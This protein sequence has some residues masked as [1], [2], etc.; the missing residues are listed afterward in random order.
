MG[1]AVLK[2]RRGLP[3]VAALLALGAA[4]TAARAQPPAPPPVETVEAP[5]EQVVVEPAAGADREPP[6]RPDAAGGADESGEDPVI[7]RIEVRSDAPLD[8]PDELR[9]LIALAPGER[10]TERAVRRTLRNVQ[11]TGEA[12]EV[13]LYTRPAAPLPDVLKRPSSASAGAGG[14]R[15]PSSASAVDVVLVLRAAVQVEELVV[16]GELGRFERNELERE[17][18]VTVRQPLIESR[19][20]RGVFRLQEVYEAWG[21][22]DA[23]V[24]L[25]V[26]V[27]EA[28]RHARVTYQ[29]AA[30]PRARIGEARF[31]GALGPFTH[32]QLVERLH[33]R[34]GVFYRQETVRDS[35]ERLQEWLVGQGYRTA[36]VGVPREERRDELDLVDLTYPVEAGPKVEVEIVGAPRKELEKND[37]LPFLGDQGYDEA[38]VAQAVDRVRAYYQEKGH[39]QVEVGFEEER[40]GDV[41]RLRFEVVPGPVFTLQEID[42]DGNEEVSDERLAELMA[43]KPRR[44]LTLG[45]GRLVD[46]VLQDDLENIR[47]YY[48]LQGFRGYEI[49]RPEIDERDRDLYLTIPIAEGER[50]RVVDLELEGVE[51]LAEGEVRAQLALRSGGPYHPLLVEESVQILRSLYEAAG[52]LAAQVS[53]REEWNDERTLVDVTLRVIEGP[54]TVLDRLIIRGNVKT[55]RDVIEDAADLR[56]GEPVSRVRLLEVERS[57]YELGIF[58]RVAVDLGPADLSEPTRDVIIRVQEGRTRRVS[59]GVGYDS[60]DGL[61]VLLGYRQRNLFGRAFTFQS[62]LRYGERQRLIRAILD[63]PGFTRYDIPMLYTVAA[64]QEELPSYD[65]DRV[66]TQVEAVHVKQDWRYGL[67][68]DYRIVN[69]TITA[70]SPDEVIVERRDQDIRI[71]SLIPN[72]L[73]DHR[74]D[75]IEPTRGWSGNLRFQWAF[76]VGNLTEA[77]FLKTFVQHTHY[78]ELGWGH[79]AGSV[80]VGAIEPL[81]D[82]T[83]DL[84]GAAD[85]PPNLKIPIDE[86]FFAGGDFS[87]RAYDKDELGIPEATLFADGRGRGGNGMALL[88][89]DFRFPVWGP[90]GGALFYDTGNVWPD[91]RDADPSELKSGVGLEVRY[92]SPI[93]P[94][95]AGVGYQLNPDP[96]SDDRYHLFLAVGNPF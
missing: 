49:G 8:R 57:L 27:D 70:L 21:Y 93:G 42:F 46:G 32:E 13:E 74:N 94:V 50:R 75:P 35:A 31:E 86:R 10:L 4:A 96:G 14:G 78:F 16:E 72:V 30:G 81:I 59:Y 25:A 79:L 43:T 7:E 15:E 36:Q 89:L 34:P 22:F 87:H 95:R 65:V 44:L 40:Q 28:T 48:A 61:A 1:S 54:R 24:R 85:E 80:R 29:V 23:T 88:N 33:A 63:Q 2:R 9:E 82:L 18:P 83:E 73:V 12:Y 39:W 56:P 26:A 3:A 20:L 51:A 67:A 17:I 58:Q 69:S 91:W 77:D 52:Y 55:A 53:A 47:S 62:D 41:L 92:L 66:V 6:A 64:Q 60:D 76:P 71:S 5:E 11:A 45:S 90:V 68:F 37:L 84:P 19:L 38:L